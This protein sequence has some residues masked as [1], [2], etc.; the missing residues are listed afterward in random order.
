MKKFILFS[1]LMAISFSLLSQT[2]VPVDDTV[3][4]NFGDI[5]TINPLL[6]DYD[7]EGGDL[8]ISDAGVPEY[9]ELLSFNDSLVSFKVSDYNLSS[10]VKVIYQLESDYPI[11]PSGKIWVMFKDYSN[12]L[13][14]NQVS[15]AVYPM[16]IQFWDAYTGFGDVPVYNY[17]KDATTTTMFNM[18]LW[19]GGKNT[20]DDLHFAGERYRQM[21]ADFW[22]GPLSQG[23]ELTC[24]SVVAGE[25]LRTWKVT[26]DEVNIHMTEFADPDYEMPE[27]ILNWPAHGDPA[28]NQAEFIAP[29][30][31]VDQDLEY[32]PELGDY[33]FIKGDESIFFVY[34]DQLEHTE[35]EGLPMGLEIHCM[36]WGLDHDGDSPYE[37]TIFYSYKIFNRSDETY[38]DTYLGLFADIDLGYAGDDYVGCNVEQGYYFAY[39]GTEIDGNGEPGSFGEN[40]PSQAICMLGGPFMDEDNL[41]NPL[42]LCDEGINGAGF[43]DGE[44][45]N[46]RYG[47][48]SFFYFNNGGLQ[49]QYDP[50]TAD[51]YYNLLQG[52][53]I[54][55][56]QMCYGG[57]GHSSAGGDSLFLTKFMFPGDSDPC[58]WGTGGLDPNVSQSWTEDNAGNNPGDRRGMSSMGPFTFEAGSVEYLDIAL[59]TAPGD[60]VK[61]STELLQDFISEIKTDYLVNP[62]SFGNQHVGIEDGIQIESLLEVYPNPINGNRIHFKIPQ[63][64]TVSYK[65]YNT[66]G[67][68][69]QEADL[70]AQENQSIE[71][72]SLKAGW[73]ILEVQADHKIFRSKLIK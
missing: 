6:N 27:A 11:P 24:D 61:S 20:E 55:G 1:F 53:W 34:N 7:T 16:N 67:Q 36:A 31:D 70:E 51:E 10:N 12:A 64:N 37:S 2:Q 73:Y 29:F 56:S 65:I 8:I 66:A 45:D 46:E 9:F 62:E 63:S 69:V 40:P 48:G 18:G 54:D 43:G 23:N 25:W 60:Q 68:L 59:V 44:I 4:V 22:P 33:P 19:I 21:G 35:S 42:G 14:I 71:V 57:N 47:M 26:R 13:E 5:I 58:H 50:S 52:N 49:Y 38:Y 30:V 15:A 72:G 17:P 28:K 3:Y 39:N 32:H 41:D